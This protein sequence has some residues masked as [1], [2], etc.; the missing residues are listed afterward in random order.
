MVFA[1]ARSPSLQTR[2]ICCLS[3]P[4]AGLQETVAT[5]LVGLSRWDVPWV[6]G[7][8]W[9]QCFGGLSLVPNHQS[10]RTAG[11]STLNLQSLCYLRSANRLE[12]LQI[13]SVES[14][15]MPNRETSSTTTERS[16]SDL[17]LPD[18]PGRL[19]SAPW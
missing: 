10:R 18:L 14:F 19:G 3:I 15:S 13:G 12:I 8:S 1:S 17:W 16:C 11:F 9:V 6:T 2:L 5:S 7:Q 4:M